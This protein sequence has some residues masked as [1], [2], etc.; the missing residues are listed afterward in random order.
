[1]SFTGSSDRPPPRAMLK[2]GGASG[3]WGDS[4]TGIGPLIAAGV[5]VLM[6][7]YLAEVTMSLL[8]RARQKD[9]EAGYPPDFISYLAPHLPEI[10]RRGVR[11]VS[12]AGGV[13]PRACMRALE[14]AIA[15]AGV[16][17]KIA[18]VEGDDLMPLLD[19]LRDE[20]VREWQTGEPIPARMLT[21]NAYLGARP[22]AAAL[23]AGADIVITGRCVDSALAL[24]ALMHAFEWRASDY[25]RLAAGSLVGHLLECGPQSTGGLLTDWQ[26]VPGWESIGYPIAECLPDGRFFITKPEGTGGIVTPQTVS[27]QA[28]YEVGD[29]AAYI[30]PDVVADFSHVQVAQAGTDRVLVS[31]ARGAPPTETL[32]VS[33]T[34]QS[35]WRATALVVII[36][37]QAAAK[38]ERSAHAL[39]ARARRLFAERGIAD[40]DAIHIE[41][42]GAEASYGSLSRARDTREV[43]MRLVVDHR[44]PKALSLLAREVG[45]SALGFA[46]GT[47]ALIGGR[48]KPTPIVR[49]FSF[50]VDKRRVADTTVQ[51]GAGP[52]LEVPVEVSVQGPIA[53]ASAAPRDDSRALGDT[54]VL[55]DAS[56]RITVPLRR[57]A[58]ARSGDKGNTANVAIFCRR[59]EFYPWLRAHLSAE[60]MAQHFADSV[61]GRVQRF[62]APG[63]HAFN[64]LMDEALGGGGMASRRIDPLG[65]AMG[66]RALDLEIDVP[67]EWFD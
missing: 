11:V 23:D 25:D 53:H 16:S 64:F 50:L 41:A 48:P 28:L 20:D 38:A 33:A 2:I 31:G 39:V 62:E 47:A 57:I 17:L 22:I 56:K 29:P 7:D 58:H 37:D 3:A 42:L 21:A 30:L 19:T 14:Q 46:Q 4:P 15:Q 60:R 32:K 27:E 13:N 24:G 6:M 5:D 67:A 1:M 43:V 66:Q 51:I 55:R 65:K 18:V 54:V 36:G 63:L 40:F 52:V 59:P 9:P 45:S 8:A 34:W 35:G 26:T 44:D 49:M 61:E 12:N 10:A